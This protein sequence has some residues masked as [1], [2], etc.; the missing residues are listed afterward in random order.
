[1]RLKSNIWVAAY[2]RRCQV[3]GVAAVLRR[4]GSE[5][6]GA[7]FIVVDRLDGRQ[8]LYGPAPQ[9]S[10]AGHP[11]M[12]RIFVEIGGVED[13]GAVTDRLA[14]ELRFDSDLWV[15]DV[16]DRAGRHFLDLAEE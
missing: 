6:A 13:G 12:D 7:I 2:I 1:M 14:R 9:T 4:R 5:E 3:E 8:V 15:V 11:G 16:E 10:T